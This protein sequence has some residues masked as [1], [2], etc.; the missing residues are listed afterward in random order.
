MNLIN[1]KKP[2]ETQEAFS[3]LAVGTG[4]EPATPCVTGTYSN[5]LNYPTVAVKRCKSN[6]NFQLHK[7]FHVIFFFFPFAPC[8]L[9][10]N[11]H[12]HSLLRNI[13]LRTFLP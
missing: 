1:K 11:R 12:R 10:I 2:L 7:L 13:R 6:L 5:Q 4:L 9:H 8:A 3:L